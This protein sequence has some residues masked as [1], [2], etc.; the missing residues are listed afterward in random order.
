MQLLIKSVIT[1]ALVVPL[2]LVS[3]DAPVIK[4]GPPISAIGGDNDA[5]NFKGVLRIR[6]MD[7]KD[8]VAVAPR[9]EKGLIAG[10][11]GAITPGNITQDA[12]PGPA[13]IVFNEDNVAR[14]VKIQ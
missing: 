9:L 7:Y 14:D 5:R 1:L 2:N 3:A 11:K 4:A 13:D 12:L 10:D 6:P 8:V